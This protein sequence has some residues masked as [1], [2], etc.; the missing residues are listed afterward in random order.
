ML[1]FLQKSVIMEVVDVALKDKY[2]RLP[3]IC[4]SEM[5]VLPIY[6]T[7]ENRSSPWTKRKKLRKMRGSSEPK[8]CIYA[9]IWRLPRHRAKARC[10]EISY[11]SL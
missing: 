8:R 6:M 9:D 7:S 5:T 10:K 4:I 3:G 11:T 1:F 2:K